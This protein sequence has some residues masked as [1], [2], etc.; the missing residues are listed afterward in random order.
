MG[1]IFRADGAYEFFSAR[2]VNLITQAVMAEI[3]PVIEEAAPAASAVA[4]A[5]R[6]RR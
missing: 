3:A 6:A 2:A 1:S 4:P 5:R